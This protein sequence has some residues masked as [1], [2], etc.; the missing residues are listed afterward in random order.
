M[1]K[2]RLDPRLQRKRRRAPLLIKRKNGKRIS[3][4]SDFIAAM[5]KILRHLR[6]TKYVMKKTDQ[7]FNFNTGVFY[8]DCSGLIEGLMKMV[9]SKSLINDI[10]LHWTDKKRLSRFY[11]K[12][13][14]QMAKNPK[15]PHGKEIKK[16][17]N[18]RAGDIWV[19]RYPENGKHKATGHV[20]LVTNRPV[21]T[22][23]TKVF[24]AN[25]KWLNFHK[26]IGNFSMG[27]FHSSERG[28]SH[29]VSKTKVLL[30]YDFRQH[31]IVSASFDL[32]PHKKKFRTTY[33][34]TF[35]R[36]YKN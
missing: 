4:N 12:N 22:K 26:N 10:K 15:F 11:A 24:F 29:G 20:M 16:I 7:I 25:E 36:F 1:L 14:Y 13:F 17:E 18:V 19:M 3:F 2:R 33:K 8:T 21:E 35:L 23:R 34:N 31:K 6:K 9:M 28:T 32:P 27:I 30:K 5:E